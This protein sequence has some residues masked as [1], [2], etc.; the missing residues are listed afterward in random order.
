MQWCVRYEARG[1]Q[2]WI[3]QTDRL[4]EIKGAS[5]LVERIPAL[6]GATLKHLG[7]GGQWQI[8]SAAAGGA[9]I[10]FP[11]A[12]AARRFMSVWPLILDHHVPGLQVV[13]ALI[14]PD[15][16]WADMYARLGAARNDL[17]AELPQAG[18]VVMRAPSTGRPAVAPGRTAPKQDT[19]R[20]F[21]DRAL[22]AR[23]QAGVIEESDPVGDRL[24]EGNEA[25]LPERFVWA[26]DMNLLDSRYVAVVHAD[27]NDLGARVQRMQPGEL[28]AL[29]EALTDCT[30]SASRSALRA[31]LHTVRDLDEDLPVDDTGRTVLPLRPIVLGGDDV[32]AIVR[33][34]LA[35]VFA[36]TWLSAF[37]AEGEK[38]RGA[39]GGSGVTACAGIAFVHAGYPFHRAHDLAEQLCRYAKD[40]LRGGSVTPSG[41]A[42]HRVS[43]SITGH[44]NDILDSELTRGGRSLSFM[45][46]TMGDA[47]R[48]PSVAALDRLVNAMADLP[49]GPLRE[50]IGRLLDEPT[51]AEV[52]R[53]R[54]EAGRTAWQAMAT[55]LDAFDQ[56]GRPNSS[57][58]H[59]AWT[60]SSMQQRQ[61]KE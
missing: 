33:A 34:D 46:Y 5:A 9:N 52:T 42:F 40:E 39:L 3:F 43:A 11:G 10:R 20:R 59:D 54:G 47:G 48:H 6:L 55:A 30:L 51:L 50:A 24:I 44:W 18:P 49:N 21:R 27:G 8:E 41:L 53:D 60:W 14:G 1:I 56:L 35:G 61:R 15:D 36:R 58:M 38:R 23:H 22:F 12:T 26:N 4:K 13:L 32:T 31:V 16:T 29:S 28:A 37:Q 2:S 57:P 7:T 17:V 25:D 45:P 19:E